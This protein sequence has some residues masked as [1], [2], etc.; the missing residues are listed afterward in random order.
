MRKVLNFLFFS[1]KIKNINFEKRE[2]RF[3]YCRN[4]GTELPDGTEFCSNCGVNPATGQTQV[5]PTQPFQTE[6]TIPP[7]YQQ[8]SKM[9][10]GLLGIFLG[11]LGVHQFYLGN[12]QAGVIRIVVSVVT[13]GIG[14]I[15]G[16]IEGIMIL[17]GT[18]D[19]DA[20][21]VPLSD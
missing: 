7:G 5:P 1:C 12:N 21:G 13:C 20:N 17:T 15:W 4:C 19:K 14:S 10:A 16:F 8:K 9:V 3:M 6:G 18:P 11:G 2:I